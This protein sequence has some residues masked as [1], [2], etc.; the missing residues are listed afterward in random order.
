MKESDKRPSSR[1]RFS[2]EERAD[3]AMKKYIDRSD[4]AADKLDKA[5]AAIPTKKVLRRERTF[6]ET[7]GKGKTRLHFEEMEKKPNGRL[8]HNPFSRPIQ[9]LRASAHSKIRQVEQENV[10]VEAGHQG[11]LLSE[12]G[13]SYAGSKVRTAIRH[14]KTKPWRNATKAEQDSIKANA[15]YLYQKALHDNPSLAT[16]NPLSRFIQK[17]HIKRSYVKEMRKTGQNTKKAAAT[18]KSAAVRAKE[19]AKQ[20]AAAIKGNWKVILIVVA[21]AAVVMLLIGGI[22]SCSMMFGSG[23]G[24][25]M[26][27]SY[28]SEDADIYAAENTYLSKEAN[29]R[30]IL[31]NISFYYPGYD[32]YNVSADGIGHDPYILIS[33]LSALHEGVFTINDVQNELDTLFELQYKLTVEAIT[34]TRYRT[35]MRIGS[36]EVTDEETGEVSTV[37]YEYEVEVP[38]DYYIL[39]VSFDNVGFETLP[40]QILDAEQLNLFATYMA[41]LGNRE[42]LFPDSQYNQ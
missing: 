26:G 24:T 17:Q 19:T 13:V 8:H 30:D 31:D 4:K 1:L 35:E 32:E 25:M 3:P 12:H 42:D 11:E 36:Y 39:N 5:K 41:T 7:T 15:E 33:I 22:S 14:H 34:E 28:L 6:D 27:S 40:A 20:A 18:A 37:Y 29:M 9:E 10:G 16:S 21:I 38:Y 2:D 23:S